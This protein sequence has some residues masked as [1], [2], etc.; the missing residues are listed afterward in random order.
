[1]SAIL[2][3]PALAERVRA[4]GG[5]WVVTGAAGFI[6]SHLVQTLLELGQEVVG[7]DNFATGQVSNLE[8]VERTVGAVRWARF[9]FHEGDITRSADCAKAVEGARVVLHQA[10]LGSVPRSLKDPLGS[11]IANVNGTLQVFL[12]AREANVQRVVYAASSSSYGDNPRLPKV[13]DQI[14]RPLSPYA[15]TKRINEQYAEVFARCYGFSAVGLRYFNVFGPRQDPDGPYAAVIPKWIGQLLRGQVCLINGDGLTSRDFTYVANVVAANLH[16]ALASEETAQGE[17]YNIAA[18]HRTTL[19][20]LFT[21]IRDG[22]A[23]RLSHRSDL[24]SVMPSYGPERAGDVKHSLADVSKAAA[25]L[26]YQPLVTVK[27][28]VSATLDWYVQQLA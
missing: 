11:H 20:E 5:R 9:T 25:R 12:S 14:G 3:P 26:A 8:D 4:N 15:L 16:A 10:A 18:G 28:G 22:L 21:L 24:R 2:L 19:N 23:D 6:G 7:L 17:V 1:M 13:E 27:S